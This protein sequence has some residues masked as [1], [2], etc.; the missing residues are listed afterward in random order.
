MATEACGLCDG[1]GTCQECHGLEDAVED[2]DSCN[3]TGDCADC[4]G[5][6]E[7]EE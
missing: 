3:G 7:T 1:S 2:C 6:G 4:D 5:S